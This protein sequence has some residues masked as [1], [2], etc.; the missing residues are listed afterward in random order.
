MVEACTLAD[1]ES[2]IN[3][4]HAAAKASGGI[5]FNLKALLHVIR[6]APV[7]HGDSIADG[8][9]ADLHE[10]IPASGN[11][12]DSEA[13]KTELASLAGIRARSALA[14][15]APGA[16][17]ST[18][19]ERFQYGGRRVQRGGEYTTDSKLVKTIAAGIVLASAGAVVSGIWP[20]VEGYLVAGGIMPSL[21][22]SGLSRVGSYFAAMFHAGTSCA[23]RRKQYELIVNIATGM[24]LGTTAIGLGVGGWHWLKEVVANALNATTGKL[25]SREVPT[26]Q[27]PELTQHEL[28]QAA[29]A[30]L[31]AKQ[32]QA[33]RTSLAAVPKT[34]AAMASAGVEVEAAKK[35]ME[36]SKQYYP[37]GPRDQPKTPKGQA[38]PQSSMRT[39]LENL[40]PETPTTLAEMGL[41]HKAAM[42]TASAAYT[43]PTDTLPGSAMDTGKGGKRRATRGGKRRGR[44]TRGG[45]RR[46]GNGGRVA[47]GMSCLSGV[48]PPGSVG[49]GGKRR[50][51]RKTRGGKRRGLR[52]TRGGK[53]GGRRNTRGGK[54]VGRKSRR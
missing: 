47:R 39:Q 8:M 18:R 37:E 14:P 48:C 32:A 43:P 27:G 30:G 29:M 42:A 6:Q 23:Q 16:R 52:K 25:L 11:L 28:Q 12:K 1:F 5:D 21:C 34:N 33:V 26:A 20:V 19:D 45:K 53:R 17:R 31:S 2:C 50:G 24:S 38:Y 35:R 54:R 13:V 9:A 36:A 46:G 3:G 10:I 51:S 7:S 22:G 49:G 40:P 15:G 41:A 44:K 4:A